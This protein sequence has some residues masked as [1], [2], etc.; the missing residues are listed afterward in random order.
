MQVVWTGIG[1]ATGDDQRSFA[2]VDLKAIAAWIEWLGGYQKRDFRTALQTPGDADPIRCI[3]R[4]RLAR[5][6]VVPLGDSGRQPG[7]Y[8]GEL[9]QNKAQRV[10]C[11]ATR[12]S[13]RVGAIASVGL[14]YSASAPLGYRLAHVVKIG[15]QNLTDV[16]LLDE[17]T[18]VHQGWVAA[19]LESNYCAQRAPRPHSH[20]GAIHRKHSCQRAARA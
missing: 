20:R 1:R 15:R 6:R 10:D 13:Q 2:A 12:D 16:T 8:L 7:G 9:T 5:V 11:V 3:D 14:P 17:L 18:G 4:H 19:C